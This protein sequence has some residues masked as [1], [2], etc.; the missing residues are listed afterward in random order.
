MLEP[1]KR[2]SICNPME[3]PFKS[4]GLGVLE[5]EILTPITVLH[6]AKPK[7]S[8]VLCGMRKKKKANVAVRFEPRNFKI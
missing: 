1:G 5:L 4:N 2:R 3:N 6:Q 8:V 7:L